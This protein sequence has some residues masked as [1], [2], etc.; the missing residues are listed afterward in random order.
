VSSFDDLSLGVAPRLGEEVGKSGS[1]EEFSALVDSGS[2]ALNL[3]AGGES[4][5]AILSSLVEDG[6]SQVEIGEVRVVFPPLKGAVQR[7][8][9]REA[10]D[11]AG[12]GGRSTAHSAEVSQAGPHV[13]AADYESGPGGVR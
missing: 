2:K 5:N 11:A 3:K 4:S 7:G 9:R 12:V 8:T 1:E 10:G 13:E 6:E